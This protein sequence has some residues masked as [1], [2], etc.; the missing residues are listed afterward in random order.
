MVG[1]RDRILGTFSKALKYNRDTSQWENEEIA[2][3]GKE[4]D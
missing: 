1:I 4:L 3:S 2:W